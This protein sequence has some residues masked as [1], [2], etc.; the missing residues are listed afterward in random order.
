M[1]ENEFA[2]RAYDL[3]NEKPV[4]VRGMNGLHEFDS[5]FDYTATAR[6]IKSWH[7][8][9]GGTQYKIYCRGEDG[10][11]EYQSYSHN[12]NSADDLAEV[13]K[14]ISVCEGGTVC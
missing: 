4:K 8:S 2:D 12:V 5:R 3:Y 1:F 13:A 7:G 11:G 10:D 14:M 9:F 6:V